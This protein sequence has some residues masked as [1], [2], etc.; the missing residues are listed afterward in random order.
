MRKLPEH[1][2]FSERSIRNLVGS[3]DNLEEA[4]KRLGHAHTSTTAKFYRLKPTVVSP[5]VPNT[6]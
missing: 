2:R 5:L 3:E 1:Q 4:S 6:G